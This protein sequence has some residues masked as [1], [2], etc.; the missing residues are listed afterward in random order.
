[1]D[2]DGRG[3]FVQQVQMMAKRLLDEM[4]LSYTGSANVAFEQVA[5]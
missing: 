2:D 5:S 4:P 1:M 3:K